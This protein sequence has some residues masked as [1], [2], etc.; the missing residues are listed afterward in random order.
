MKENHPE[1]PEQSADY[2]CWWICGYPWSL[3]PV[4]LNMNLPSIQFLILE[5]TLTPASTF[6]RNLIN[7]G[8]TSQ[9]VAMVITPGY[10]WTSFTGLKG[11]EPG[12]HQILL[13]S[14]GPRA[15]TWSGQSVFGFQLCSHRQGTYL[16]THIDCLG[17]SEAGVPNIWKQWC[18]QLWLVLVS[19]MTWTQRH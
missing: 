2:Q 13:Y 18:R 12:K 17:L 3:D 10:Q 15:E 8:L 19:H 7:C 4:K 14:S 9:L 16:H 11:I 1:L 5:E 6:G